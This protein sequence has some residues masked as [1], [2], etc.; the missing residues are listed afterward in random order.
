MVLIGMNGIFAFYI[1]M[2]DSIVSLGFGSGADSYSNFMKVMYIFMAIFEVLRL[3][4]IGIASIIIRKQNFDSK[5]AIKKYAYIVC[6]ANIFNLVLYLMTIPSNSIFVLFEFIVSILILVG[7]DCFVNTY[8]T[9]YNLEVTIGPS[10]TLLQIMK[11]LGEAAYTGFFILI[12][13]T[14]SS[15]DF[16]SAF[17]CFVFLSQICFAYYHTKF[18]EKTLKS[19]NDLKEK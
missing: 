7:N 6:I 5:S 1:Q 16:F 12:V 9:M 11:N 4:G 15:K 13:S 10:Y 18:A 14:S 3:L 19:S 8:M 17:Q 2:L